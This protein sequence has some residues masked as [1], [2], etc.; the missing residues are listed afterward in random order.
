VVVSRPTHRRG[1]PPLVNLVN[2]ENAPFQK[3][4]KIR[5]SKVYSLHFLV[6]LEL[7]SYSLIMQKT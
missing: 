6:Y 4:I 1:A 3:R 7:S 2:A 5:P